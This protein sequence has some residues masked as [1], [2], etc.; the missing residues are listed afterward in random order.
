MHPNPSAF[1]DLFTQ[2]IDAV[3]TYFVRPAD[4]DKPSWCVY[5]CHG[6][7]GTVHALPGVHEDG[8]RPLWHVQ[9][10]HER[11]IR[12]DDAVRALRR[13]QTWPNHLDATRRW[14]RQ[15]LRDR[16]LVVLDIQTTGLHHAWAVQIAVMDRD[17]RILFNERINPLAAVTPGAET[18]HGLSTRDT[19]DAPT[20]G[21][22]LPDLTRTI[23][24][25]T[26][27]VYNAAFGREVV[28]REL[29]R[30]NSRSGVTG[31]RLRSEHWHDVMTRYAVWK[32]LWAAHRQAYRY[33]RFGSAYEAGAN[34]R[35]LLDLVTSMASRPYP[36][37]ETLPTRWTW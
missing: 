23:Q 17:H 3:P 19:L 18:L 14:A 8:Q 21:D 32:G 16:S 34:C 20:F 22:L 28:T 33:Q 15:Q 30:L 26:C 13:P 10:L 5:D 36:A 25:R 11:H 24:G 6:Y 27:L 29:L 1:A 9:S 12:L 4:T 35:K 7:R 37:P 2:T 31:T